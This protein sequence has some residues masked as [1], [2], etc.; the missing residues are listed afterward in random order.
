[1]LRVLASVGILVKVR[2][3]V[4]QCGLTRPLT[5]PPQPPFSPLPRA[6]G[7]ALAQDHGVLEEG[8]PSIW[9]FD[10]ASGAGTKVGMQE[11]GV[12]VYTLHV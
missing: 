11:E 7:M 2:G 4:L 5:P 3:T 6:D 10:R 1:M 8:I 12:P 9:A